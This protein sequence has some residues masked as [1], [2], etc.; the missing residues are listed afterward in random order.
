[1]PGVVIGDGAVIGAHSVVAKSVAPYA[2][3]VGNPAREIRT[4]FEP[5]D[6]ERLLTARWWDWPIELI[7]E[8]AATIMGG[9]PAQLAAIQGKAVEA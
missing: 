8:S 1:M 6:V 9:T 7:T 4:R 5:A 2:V 3:V